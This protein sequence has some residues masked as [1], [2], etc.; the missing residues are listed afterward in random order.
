MSGTAARPSPAAP[1][2]EAVEPE[3]LAEDDPA[4][5]RERQAQVLRL[6]WDR[7]RTL[8]RAAAAGLVVS[9]L[10]AFLFPKS[11]S[12]TAQLMPPDG[13]STSGAAVTMIAAMATKMGGGMGSSLGG[14][15]GDLLGLKTSGALFIG[16]LRS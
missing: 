5:A 15:A 7:R 6:L 1:V 2:T 14:V 9:V 8:F 3:I 12:S 10:V 13:Q 4:S 11:Y 16:M